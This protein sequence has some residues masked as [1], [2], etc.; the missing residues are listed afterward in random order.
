MALGGLVMAFTG[1]LLAAASLGI[2]SSTTGRLGMVLAGILISL[3][4]IM[5]PLNRAYQKNAV[6]KR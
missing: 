3:V 6:W 5:G 2:T 4:G 1:F